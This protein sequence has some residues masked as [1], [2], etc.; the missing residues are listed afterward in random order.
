MNTNTIIIVVTILLLML[1][2]SYIHK[3]LSDVQHLPFAFNNIRYYPILK[4]SLY[5]F[6]ISCQCV[7]LHHAINLKKCMQAYSI[8]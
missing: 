8:H 2:P 5:I 1:W 7:I 3:E 4:N 6:C